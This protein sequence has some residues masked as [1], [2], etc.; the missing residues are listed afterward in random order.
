M[1]KIWLTLVTWLICASAAGAQ[2]YIETNGP[3][4]DDDFYRLVACAA[5]PGQGCRDAIVRWSPRAARNI[6]I[7][8]TRIDDSFPRRNARLI[9][10][11]LTTAGQE[12]AA[13]NAGVAFTTTNT[14]PDIRVLLMDHP[15][16]TRLRGTGIP[17][18]DGN[19]IEAARFQIWWN[20]DKHI[21]R[22]VIVIT[23]HIRPSDIRSMVLEEMTQSLGLM[24]DIRNPT[25]ANSSIFSQDSN[26]IT[27]LQGQDAMAVRRHYQN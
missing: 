23:P 19:F 22:G 5:P 21:T 15:Q 16:N 25:Y 26:A 9:Q 13:L 14:R 11:A 8:I 24:T 27:R 3:L 17:G 4:S 12:I 6:T 1:T 2:D 20:G 10:T 7:G 18:L